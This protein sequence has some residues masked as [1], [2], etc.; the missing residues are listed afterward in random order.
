MHAET[1]L[2]VKGNETK[3]RESSAAVH[4]MEVEAHATNEIETEDL[5]AEKSNLSGRNGGAASNQLYQKTDR[6]SE[7]LSENNDNSNFLG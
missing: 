7:S 3:I 1:S 4:S 6:D 5:T 2:S